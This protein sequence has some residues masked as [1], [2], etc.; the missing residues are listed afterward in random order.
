MKKVLLIAVAGLFIF[1]SCKKDWN[2]VCSSGS[3]SGTATTYTDVSKKD[4]KESCEALE[5]L[6]KAFDTSFSCKVEAK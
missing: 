2:C 5:N 6:G 3:S 4:A 1:S